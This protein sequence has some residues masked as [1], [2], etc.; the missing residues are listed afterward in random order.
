[1]AKI[2][3]AAEGIA[4]GVGIVDEVVGDMVSEVDVLG[5][6]LQ[7]LYRFGGVV[8]TGLGVMQNIAPAYTEPALHGFTTLAGKSATRLVKGMLGGVAPAKA[9][10]VPQ[11]RAIVRQQAQKAAERVAAM[12]ATAREPEEVISF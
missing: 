3:L 9:L 12:A 10:G 8:L 1:M 5:L 7:T 2:D 4:V 6:D 11:A